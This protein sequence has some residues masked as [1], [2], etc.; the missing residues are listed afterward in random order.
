MPTVDTETKINQMENIISRDPEGRR[1][2]EM[3]YDFYQAA[4][5][6]LLKA[7]RSIAD[8]PRPHI[9]I[10]SGCYLVHGEPPCCETDGPPGTAHL[11]SGLWRAGIPCRVLTDRP[12]VAA[13]R[14][15]LEAADLPPD[16]PLDVAT[17]IGNGGDNRTP[18]DEIESRWIQM[19]P[20]LTHVVSIERGGPS[21]DG[22]ARSAHNVEM[23]PYNAPLERLF[24]DRPWKSIGL[25]DGGNELG[26]GNLPH[27]VVAKHV[28]FGDTIA[29]RV[30]CD[31]LLVCGVSNWGAAAL[32]C[33]LALL[34]PE[35]R[36]PLTC[37]LTAETD[38]H[39]LEE[40]VFKGPAVSMAFNLLWGECRFFPVEL[41]L[42]DMV[43]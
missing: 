43:V 15:A 23:T 37:G 9:G 41:Q 40:C 18:M 13:I 31:Y 2:A 32:L 10:I 27:S 12:N 20:P 17:A 22:V 11:A 3:M 21:A 36:E 8:H 33:A 34:K 19:D 29:C 30:T 16:F 7:A 28:R 35:L 4:K 24:N 5:G 42:I 26:M 6:N 38:R 25:G 39:I 14:A 1:G